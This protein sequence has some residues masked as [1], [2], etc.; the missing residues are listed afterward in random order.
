MLEIKLLT[1]LN[2]ICRGSNISVKE[3]GKDIPVTGRGGP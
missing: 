2:I 1:N 3:K